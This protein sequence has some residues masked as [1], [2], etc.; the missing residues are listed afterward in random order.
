MIQLIL[1]LWEVIQLT[2]YNQEFDPLRPILSL[3][4]CRIPG[5]LVELET[6]V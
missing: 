1:H 5:L 4:D 6:I 3:T 2:M